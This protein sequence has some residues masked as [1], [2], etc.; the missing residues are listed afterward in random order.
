MGTVS[1]KP[2][3]FSGPSH[4]LGDRSLLHFFLSEMLF[5]LPESVANKFL[6]EWFLKWE[7]HD[8]RLG[9]DHEILASNQNPA[10]SCLTSPFHIV[11]QAVSYMGRLFRIYRVF[12]QGMAENLGSRLG[13]MCKAGD[14][15]RFEQVGEAEA[16]QH[17]K[18]PCIEVGDDAQFEPMLF[19]F[20]ENTQRLRVEHPPFRTVEGMKDLLEILIEP[21][22]H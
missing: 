6:E 15:H 9:L 1:Q 19:Q 14:G 7:I 21:L 2:G 22:D 8:S 10:D 3:K 11:P 5:K 13:R 16:S 4:A 20:L 12:L 17:I 18:Q